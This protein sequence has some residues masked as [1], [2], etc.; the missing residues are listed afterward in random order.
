MTKAKLGD[1]VK[2]HYTGKLKDGTEFD[3]SFPDD[4]L[5]FTIGSGKIIPGFEEAVIGMSPGQSKTEEILA[6]QAYGSHQEEM[7]LEVDRDK[8][9]S[10][11]SPTVGQQLEVRYA[12]N[13]TVSVIVT[14][15]SDTILT[16]D[17]NHPLAGKD[18]IFEIE[19]M[20]IT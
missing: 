2:V 6:E 8:I 12:D 15:V 7:V 19:L 13:R 20:E 4:P 11:I 10:H 5:Q 16:L 14:E 9:P 3:T 18:L 17:A 1:T